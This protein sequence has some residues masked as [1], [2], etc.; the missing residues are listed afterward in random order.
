MPADNNE[1][2]KGQ[3]I[4]KNKYGLVVKLSN[5]EMG[6]VPN[7]QIDYQ[8]RD[9]QFYKEMKFKKIKNLKNNSQNILSL[10]LENKIGFKSLEKAMKNWVEKIGD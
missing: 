9:I 2:I 8:N 7:S 5:K 3:V 1:I 4:N 6:F 10:K